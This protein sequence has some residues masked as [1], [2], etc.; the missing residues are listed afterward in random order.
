M[1]NLGVIFDKRITWR[2][3]IEMI[4]AKAFRTF[5]R[6]YFL[7]K[8]EQLCANIKLNKALIRSIMPGSLRQPSTETAVPAKEE[9]STPLE[10]FQGTHQF[11]NCTW[12]LNFRTYMI[13]KQNYAG[14][15]KK[16]Y[17]IMKMQMFTKLDTGN[18]RS[19]KLAAVKCMTVQVTRLPL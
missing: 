11:A 12:L 19:L 14:Y 1:Q 17:R 16:S 15:K 5:I 18:I 4:E 6:I 13:I 3:H 2:L 8:S 9:F 10:T 7:F